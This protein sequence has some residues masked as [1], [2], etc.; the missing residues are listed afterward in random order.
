MPGR[1]DI[2]RT[3]CGKK[4]YG[5]PHAMWACEN[6]KHRGTRVMPAVSSI[7]RPAAKREPC[8]VVGV[9]VHVSC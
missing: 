8:L 7:D 6:E 9:D 3:S 2:P 4:S 5:S 1:F